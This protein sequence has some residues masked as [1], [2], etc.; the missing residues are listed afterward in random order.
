MEI[1]EKV[2]PSEDAEGR[3][4]PSHKYRGFSEKWFSTTY[5]SAIMD[6]CDQRA[7]HPLDAAGLIIL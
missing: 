2:I 4:L 5:N 3:L 1:L 6:R 7:A